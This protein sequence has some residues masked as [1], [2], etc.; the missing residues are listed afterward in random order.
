[1]F[2]L[3]DQFATAFPEEY[4]AWWTGEQNEA[5]LRIQNRW[6][7]IV[8]KKAECAKLRAEISRLHCEIAET[9]QKRSW[10]NQYIQVL[11]PFTRREENP[12][13]TLLNNK[14]HSLQRS[15]RANESDLERAK[16]APPYLKQ[17]LPIDPYYGKRAL[18]FVH[19][20]PLLRATWMASFQAQE[21]IFS[22]G[23]YTTPPGGTCDFHSFYKGPFDYRNAKSVRPTPLAL[24]IPNPPAKYGSENVAIIYDR[25]DGIWYQS[26][27]N[28]SIMWSGK[29]NPFIAPRKDAVE[30]FCEPMASHELNWTIIQ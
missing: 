27:F 24:F 12:A 14:V 21:M 4:N 25:N 8:L 16:Q 5:E 6:N 15:L 13:W 26:G 9:T 1:M 3:A 29:R 19:M 30:R 10:V 20:P 2:K 18:F 7:V 11:Y 23:I 17:P 28:P 22:N